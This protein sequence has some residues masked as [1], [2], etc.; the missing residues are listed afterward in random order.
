VPVSAG[1]AI[2]SSK[3]LVLQ[4]KRLLLASTEN[5]L[6]KPGSEEL[7]Q[8]AGHLRTQTDDAQHAYRSALLKW[9]STETSDYWLVA[10]TKLIEKGSALIAK[11][12]S[13][14]QELPPTDRVQMAVE[15]A[16]L[17]DAIE[18]WRREM[19]TSMAAASA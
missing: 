7:R 16:V 4:S 15:V 6:V 8:R 3:L 2:V 14:A 12:R 1:R 18:R 10:Y 11:L 17:E 5:C 19:R 9:G 13:A